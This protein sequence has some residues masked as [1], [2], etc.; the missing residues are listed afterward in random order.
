MCPPAGCARADE[1]GQHELPGAQ[2]GLANQ[3]A[4][5]SLARSRRIRV[6]GKAIALEVRWLGRYERA[7]A[8]R[9]AVPNTPSVMPAISITASR[10]L[11]L[12]PAAFTNAWMK[13]L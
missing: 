10:E 12:T 2:V 8:A 1:Q 5:A 6:C 4:Q 9:L 11:L 3:P 13:L 7:A